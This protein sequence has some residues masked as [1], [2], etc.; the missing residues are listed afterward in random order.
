MTALAVTAM[1]G[2]QCFDTDTK[3]DLVAARSLALRGYAA[4]IRYV[5]R[6]VPN[7]PGDIGA[8]EAATIMTA[9]LG[10][11]LVQHC[12]PAYWTPSSGLGTAYGGAAAQ[13]AAAV[14][15]PAGAT[16]AVDLE[17]MRPGCGNPAIV[18]YVNSW[19]RAV[20]AAGYVPCLYYSAD[21]PLSPEEL[22]L[23][24]VVTLYW[25]ALSRDTPQVA[26]CGP[27]IQQFAQM[28]QVAGIDIDRDVVMAD[29]FGRLPSWM[30]SPPAVGPIANPAGA[31]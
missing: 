1:P 30:T 23:D 9:G 10:L 15:Y 3:L 28:G 26:V 21:C 13:N 17:N 22:Y 29:A 14:G 12:P 11:M 7:G 5:S 27:C 16:L 24:L 31:L 4:A 18:A 6:A 8:E 19:S 20:I 25:R 2:A